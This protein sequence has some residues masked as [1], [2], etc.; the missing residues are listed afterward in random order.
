[1]WG[2]C[3]VALSI[4]AGLPA[5]KS[6][7][8]L[9]DS[10]SEALLAGFSLENPPSLGE[11]LTMANIATD[12]ASK[13]ERL[14]KFRQH[15]AKQSLSW[16]TGTGSDDIVLSHYERLKAIEPDLVKFNFAVSGA[17]SDDL[18]RQLEALMKQEQA[19]GRSI[20]Y[21]TVFIGAND[22]GSDS[23]EG[24][25]PPLK[26]VGNIESVAR[27]LLLRD[28]ERFILFVG[29][30]Q[31]HQIFEKSET[32]QAYK[33]LGW[34]LNCGEMRRKIYGEMSVFK[35][36]DHAAYENTKAI[37]K[38]YERGVAAL[39]ERL[40]REFPKAQLKS[41][42]GYKNP[43]GVAKSLSIDCF[44]PSEWGQ[45]ALAE[46][47]WNG[48]FWPDLLSGPLDMISD[49]SSEWGSSAQ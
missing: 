41:V 8:V 20:E 44:H 18:H 14:A 49:L 28:S 24:I 4:I 17:E 15:Y 42:V 45:A 32:L 13:E 12:S 35:P 46:V 36:D 25:T 31:I 7:A 37:F 6:M 47:T 10:M 48:G 21:V 40:S 16:A 5:P 11:I 30:P 3:L 26:F 2:S 1:M 23:P 22:L 33:L 29:L 38:E 19:M 34:D 43:L 39:P 9:G 27:E